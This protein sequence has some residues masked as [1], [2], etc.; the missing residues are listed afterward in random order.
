MICKHIFMITFLKEPKLILLH[1]D[2][3]FQVLLSNM[4]NSIY[5]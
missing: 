1:S 3:W 2:K 5:Y 4:N